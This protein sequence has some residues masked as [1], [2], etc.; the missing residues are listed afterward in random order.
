MAI[1][2]WQCYK[3]GARIFKSI[4]AL[5]N[6]PELLTI[7]FYVSPSQMQHIG[8]LCEFKILHAKHYDITN[9]P[10]S[11]VNWAKMVN[12]MTRSA[13]TMLKFLETYP[14]AMNTAVYMTVTAIIVWSEA[15]S[16]LDHTV[17]GWLWM[18][19]KQSLFWMKWVDA[20]ESPYSNLLDGLH[21]L[22]I[23]AHVQRQ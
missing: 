12:F 2:L 11:L 14:V 23:N 19:K 15:I 20:P 18:W 8:H 17:Y 13:L 4:N 9:D 10:L 3:G 16:A 21:V 22:S 6:R 1:Y 7:M 5:E